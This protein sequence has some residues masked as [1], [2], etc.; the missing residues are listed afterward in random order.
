MFR[1]W[2]EC[3]T[4]T[5]Y[6]CLFLWWRMFDILWSNRVLIVIKSFLIGSKYNTPIPRFARY[7]VYAFLLLYGY[8]LYTF[9]RFLDESKQKIL[10]CIISNTTSLIQSQNQRIISVFKSHYNRILNCVT[11]IWENWL[12][13]LHLLY[14][15]YGKSLEF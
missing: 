4:R 6:H 12:K 7:S 9:T 5:F 13:I 10:S 11:N 2:T 8:T 3:Y 15:K 14:L 1:E